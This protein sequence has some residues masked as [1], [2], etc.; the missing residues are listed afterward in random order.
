[1]RSLSKLIMVALL[2]AAPLPVLASLPASAIA[3]SNAAPLQRI[4]TPSPIGRSASGSRRTSEESSN[5]A[6]YDVTGD[7][8]TTVTATWTQPTAASTSSEGSDAAFWVGLDGDGSETVE[9]IGTEAYKENG[10]IYYDAWYEMYPS[11]S[12]TI[13]SLTISP[14]DEITAK[15][16][17]NG[18][19]SFALSLKDAT[20]GKSFSKTVANGVTSPASAEIIAEAPTDATTGSVVSLVDFDSVDFTGCAV[21]G[22]ALSSYDWNRINLVSSS[23]ASLAETSTLGSDGTSFTVSQSSDTASPTTSA[24]GLQS[25]ATKGWTDDDSVTVTLSASGGSGSLA[26]YYKVAGDSGW[27]TYSAPFTVSGEGSHK[28]R[29]YSV[30]AAGDTESTRAGF[31]NIDTVKPTSKAKATSVTRSKARKGSRLTFK[32]TLSDAQPTCGSARLTTTIAT[33]SGARLGRTT[34]AAVTVNRTR[35]LTVKLTKTLARGTYSVLTRATD[36]A[37]NLQ[38]KAGRA[39][40]TVK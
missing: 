37:G 24:T 17:A 15:V 10:R 31:V 35:T 32:V 22:A 6:G 28:V 21:D 12:V 3:A 26:T 18:N 25:S 30:D 9:Q 33:T 11:N 13:S 27:S 29:Y 40:L 14:G 23:G 8:F 16:T 39:K 19:G 2:A 1:M 38:A 7:G 34:L 4:G 20:T 36:A 5:W